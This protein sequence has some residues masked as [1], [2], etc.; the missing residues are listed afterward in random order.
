[1]DRRTFFGGA[2]V[3]LLVWLWMVQQTDPLRAAL[4]STTTVSHAIAPAPVESTD[5]PATGTTPSQAP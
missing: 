2:A 5:R 1:M 4:E 3:C